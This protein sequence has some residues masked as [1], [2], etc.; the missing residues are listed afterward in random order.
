MSIEIIKSEVLL[1]RLHVI[2]F[3]IGNECNYNILREI[4]GLSNS[5]HVIIVK[6][7][8]NWSIDLEDFFVLPE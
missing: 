7:G 4:T 6:N 1:D 8:D 2:S 3:A 5:N